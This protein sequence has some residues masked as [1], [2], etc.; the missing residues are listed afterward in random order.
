MV[1]ILNSLKH[2]A[3]ETVLLVTRSTMSP[4]KALNSKT[5]SVHGG[6]INKKHTQW[7]LCV[8]A[9]A[10]H[11]RPTAAASGCLAYRRKTQHMLSVG[12]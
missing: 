7:H 1:N 5:A 12:K 4:S 9:T 2:F 10:T 6:T 11:T 8:T 3:T